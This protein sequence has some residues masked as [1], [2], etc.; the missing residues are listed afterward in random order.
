MA[1][2]AGRQGILLLEVVG[3]TRVWLRYPPAL[4]FRLLSSFQAL[5]ISECVSP[6]P[7]QSCLTLSL[8]SSACVFRWIAIVIFVFCTIFP[9]YVTA[10]ASTLLA[11][12]NYDTVLPEAASSAFLS[13][14]LV[15]AIS[16]PPRASSLSRIAL[17]MT[18]ML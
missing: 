18:S 13:P 11:V 7:R 16:S 4:P 14:S 3:S 15:D 1:A 17:L 10:S 9:Y 2:A 12:E 5:E 8:A 6:L